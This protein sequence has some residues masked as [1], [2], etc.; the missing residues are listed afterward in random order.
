MDELVVG[1]HPGQIAPDFQNC[2]SVNGEC[3]IVQPS[4]LKGSPLIILFYP[5]EFGYIS[6]SEL[7]TLEHLKGDRN[8]IAV[9]S[10]SLAVK[11]AWMAAPRAERGLAGGISF[12]LVEDMTMEISKKY[13]MIRSMSGYSYRGYVVVN[14]NGVIVARHMNDLPI[15]LGIQESLRVYDA[16]DAGS[17]GP[18]WL[19]GDQK[20]LSQFFTPDVF[21]HEVED[22]RGRQ[23]VRTSVVSGSFAG[24]PVKTSTP[25]GGNSTPRN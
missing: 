19:P 5:V 23:T 20:L 17:T 1:C 25:I 18:D 11:N 3:T 2:A 16:A 21:S 22:I 9:S 24:S 10:G 14:S 15:G 4:K 13:G 12:P 8:V 7:L 6:P